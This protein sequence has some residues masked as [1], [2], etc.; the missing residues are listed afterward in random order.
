MCELSGLII[1]FFKMKRNLGRLNEKV[2]FEFPGFE[3]LN[4]EEMLKVRGG[5]KPKTREKDVYDLEEV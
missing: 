5:G 4:A 3:K 2:N 1:N